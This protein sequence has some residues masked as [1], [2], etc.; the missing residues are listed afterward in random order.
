MRVKVDNYVEEQLKKESLLGNK[1]YCANQKT[2][3][4][5]LVSNKMKFK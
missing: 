5:K 4:S 2:F 1:A 3:E